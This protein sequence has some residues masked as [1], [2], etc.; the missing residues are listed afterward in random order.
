MKRYVNLSLAIL[1]VVLLSSDSAFS[2]GPRGRGGAPAR[3]GPAVSGHPRPA[4]GGPATG[5]HRAGPATGPHVGNPTA[6]MNANQPRLNRNLP[7]AGNLTARQMQLNRQWRQHAVQVRSNLHGRYNNLFTPAW[8]AQHPGAWRY[9]H[10]HADMW[11]AVAAWPVLARWVGVTGGYPYGYGTVYESDTYYV[12]DDGTAAEQTVADETTETTDDTASQTATDGST[13]TSG[14][15]DWLPLGVF[16]ITRPDAGTSPDRLFQFAV[17]RNGQIGG[18][19]Y[20]AVS[21]Q[22]MPVEGA[23][24]KT[25]Q[26]AAWTV[27]SNQDVVLETNLGSFTENQAKVLVHPANGPTEEWMMVRLTGPNTNPTGTQTTTNPAGTQGTTNPS[28][29]TPTSAD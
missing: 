18:S 20:D 26:R 11:A 10:P 2:V 5:P 12:T 28:P 8:Y 9:T 17:N 27:G 4:M 1:A 22:E 14:S 6:R 3:R 25:T 13:T 21:G 23:V 15:G 24:N 16:A 19:Y 29:T 7:H